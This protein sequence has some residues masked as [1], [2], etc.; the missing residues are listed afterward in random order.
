[1]SPVSRRTGRRYAAGSQKKWGG[2]EAKV[3]AV[4]EVRLVLARGSALYSAAGFSLCGAHSSEYGRLFRQ[5][6]R[7]ET[8]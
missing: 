2:W 7:E 6:Q 4:C 3:C 8:A 1:V 5:S